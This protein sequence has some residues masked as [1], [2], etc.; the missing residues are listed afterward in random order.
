M[1]ARATGRVIRIEGVLIAQAAEARQEPRGQKIREHT[2]VLVGELAALL[3]R[4]KGV[5][6]LPQHSL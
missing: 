6:F 5:A 3:R 4:D 1:E 2:P